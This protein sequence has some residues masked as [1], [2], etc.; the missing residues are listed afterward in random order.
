MNPEPFE[1]MRVKHGVKARLE[2]L[3]DRI[4]ETEGLHKRPAL[5][6]VLRLVLDS[7]EKTPRTLRPGGTGEPAVV[8]HLDAS[9]MPRTEQEQQ[10]VHALLLFLRDKSAGELHDVL[11]VL[12][13][14]W[15][16]KVSKKRGEPSKKNIA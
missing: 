2:N 12:L 3:Q 9:L 4:R 5:S 14:P 6:D 13:R 8:S 7:Y 15:L 11:W 16:G 10:V 1:S